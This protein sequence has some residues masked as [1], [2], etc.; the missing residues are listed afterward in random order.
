M[1][2]RATSGNPLFLWGGFLLSLKPRCPHSLALA[3]DAMGAP[4]A[5]RGDLNATVSVPTFGKTIIKRLAGQTVRVNAFHAQRQQDGRVQ[6]SL[7]PPSRTQ[8][9]LV[10]AA[11]DG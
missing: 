3:F 7:R 2:S 11:R 9:H 1:S 8:E 6:S 4:F 10:S 5:L